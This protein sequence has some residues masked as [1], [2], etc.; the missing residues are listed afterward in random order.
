MRLAAAL[1]ALPHP[2]DAQRVQDD[3]V[4]FR[5]FA[6]IQNNLVSVINILIESDAPGFVANDSMAM[7]AGRFR[8][9]TIAVIPGR[10]QFVRHY[11]Y[12]HPSAEFGKNRVRV[13]EVRSLQTILPRF[14]R[15][16]GS[17]SHTVR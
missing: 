16:D 2:C 5:Q 3:G 12:S 14:E 1:A 17:Y 11:F 4:A 15:R 6:R 8:A 9:V 13:D 10:W 7:L